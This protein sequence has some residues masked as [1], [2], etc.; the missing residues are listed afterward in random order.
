MA[1]ALTVSILPGAIQD[2]G[3]AAD[4]YAQISDRVFLKFRDDFRFSV[5]HLATAYK[6]YAFVG[7]GNFRRLPMKRFPFFVYY[8]LE[9]SSGEVI[10]YAVIHASRSTRFVNRRIHSGK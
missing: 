4:Y 3:D 9:V 7:V 8:K 1:E 2:F 6:H 10:V 5:A